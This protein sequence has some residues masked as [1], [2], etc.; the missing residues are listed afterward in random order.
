VFKRTKHSPGGKH[1]ADDG[2]VPQHVVADSEQFTDIQA[3]CQTPKTGQ[4]DAGKVFDMRRRM[5][6]GI[7]IGIYNI[8]TCSKQDPDK[9]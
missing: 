6:Q 3:K 5:T 1:H 7:D 4:Q 2:N 8:T 9:F